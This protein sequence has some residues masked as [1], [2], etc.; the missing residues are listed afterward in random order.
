MIIPSMKT[1]EVSQWRTQE[2]FRGGVQGRGSGLVGGPGAE[3]HGRGRIFENLQKIPEENGNN[4]VFSPILQKNFK[5]MRSIF[6]RLDEKHDC[7]GNF[8]KFLMKI[9]WKN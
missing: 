2:K 7:L 9:Q 1:I 5:T 8:E 4:A 6:A 3:P